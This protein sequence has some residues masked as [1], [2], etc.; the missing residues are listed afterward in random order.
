MGEWGEER[1]GEGKRGERG[2]LL[3]KLSFKL[4]RLAWGGGGSNGVGWGRHDWTGCYF[5]LVKRYIDRQI[6]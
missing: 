4:E 6:S 2:N 5:E 3:D 1:G